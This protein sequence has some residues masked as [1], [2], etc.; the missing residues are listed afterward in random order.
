MLLSSTS[1]VYGDPLEHPQTEEYFGNVNCVGYRSCYDEGKRAAEAL[2]MDYHRQHGVDIRIAR[3]FNT[4]G[5]TM[6]FNDGRVVSN[7]IVQALKADPLTVY[8]TGKQTRSFCFVD[9]VVDGMIRLMNSEY[10]GPVNLGNPSEITVLELAEKVSALTGSK[11]PVEFRNLPLDDPHRR[12]PD[13]TKA[14][15]ILN[16]SPKVDLE[17]GLRATIEDFRMRAEFTELLDAHQKGADCNP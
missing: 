3:I 6:F 4:Y 2:C 9:D 13:I 12:Q 14:R 10:V 15:S 8:G 16:W 7:F 1:E 17:T 11:H 5:P